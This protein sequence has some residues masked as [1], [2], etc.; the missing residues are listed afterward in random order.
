ML[1]HTAPAQSRQQILPAFLIRQ[2][3]SKNG[4][5]L[6]FR[7]QQRQQARPAS[8]S[9]CRA[10]ATDL[11]SEL[12]K[13]AAEKGLTDASLKPLPLAVEGLVDDPSLHNPLQRMHRL[14]TGWM[15]VILEYEG[16]LVEDTSELH[17]KAWE[18]LALEEDKARPLNWLLKKAQG[19]KPTQV[20]QEV[21]C[22]SRNPM[23]V[24]RL[25]AR[26]EDM[27]RELLGDRVPMMPAGVQHLLDLLN[28]NEVPVAVACSAPEARVK[29]ALEQL[30]LTPQL[31]AVV[32]AEDVYRG[33]PD[34]EAYLLAAQ[35]LQRPPAR[36]VVV[37]NSNQSVEAA[38][39]CGMAVVVVAGRNPLY[40]LTAADLV[41][42]QL[43]ELSFINLKQLFQTEDQ[44]EAQPQTQL[45]TE[46]DTDYDSYS[47][48]LTM[49]S[50]W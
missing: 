10:F 49:D 26:K 4:V 28:A 40:E 48:N 16:V 24:R 5:G 19:M 45:E 12:Q 2:Q 3:G 44:V 41:V 46:E 1:P 9:P 31:E 36:C 38:R 27:Y 32:T 21:F 34:P 13:V 43:G 17:Q 18:Q 6:V 29:P 39:E 50:N 20:V 7:Q 25:A 30:G 22:W 42:R 33:R 8:T 11:E 37:G 47:Q 15:G 14:G 35:Q 23:E